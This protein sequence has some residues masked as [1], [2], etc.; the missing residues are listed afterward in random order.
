MGGAHGSV[1]VL[2]GNL[3]EDAVEEPAFLGGF[4]VCFPD[5][6]VFEEGRAFLAVVDGVVLTICGE[7]LANFLRVGQRFCCAEEVVH[8]GVLGIEGAVG[9]F[10]GVIYFLQQQAE[11]EFVARNFRDEDFDGVFLAFLHGEGNTG[12][13]A[14]EAAVPVRRGFVLVEG[15]TLGLGCNLALVSAVGG[16]GFLR[17]FALV[18]AVRALVEV[19]AGGDA[20]TAFQ[21]EFVVEAYQQGVISHADKTEGAALRG[22]YNAAVDDH[23]GGRVHLGGVGIRVVVAL[24]GFRAVGGFAAGQ[25]EV[26]GVE[27]D[28]RGVV[29]LEDAL[30]PLLVVELVEEVH[31]GLAVQGGSLAVYGALEV[32]EPAHEGGFLAHGV[33]E[34]EQELVV[35]R[36]LVPLFFGGVP[37]AFA[38]VLRLFAEVPSVLPQVI[39]AGVGGGGS[40]EC[41]EERQSDAEGF[42]AHVW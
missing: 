22:S 10:F 17:D 37:G 6:A 15:A 26:G 16:G 35:G 42:C 14:A 23:P 13:D 31:H 5:E 29:G 39:P 9:R 21:H 4:E 25:V 8:G 1:F 28:V 2:A 38:E 11:A 34:G 33:A 20:P 24:E 41:G 36:K 30:V 3:A 19:F 18:G 32:V 12:G 40:G 27:L 7:R